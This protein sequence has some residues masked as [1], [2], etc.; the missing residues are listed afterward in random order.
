MTEVISPPAGPGPQAGAE[1]VADDVVDGRGD[2][3]VDDEQAGGR[4]GGGLRRLHRLAQPAPLITLAVVVACTV[5]VFVQL[6]PSQL[7]KETTPAGGDMG[8]HV[9]LPAYIK[10]ELL[11]HFRI[12]GW[13][14]D[15]YAGFPA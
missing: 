11:P 3:L 14:M 12:F 6:Q 1:R 4:H 15:W 8:A 9:W 7:F 10:R 5:F 13:T 2:N